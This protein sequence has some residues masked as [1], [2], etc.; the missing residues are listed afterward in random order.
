[1][2]TSHCHMFYQI[3][4]AE[5]FQSLSLKYKCENCQLFKLSNAGGEFNLA[6]EK[7]DVKLKFVDKNIVISDTGTDKEKTVNIEK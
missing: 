2:S 1:M 3:P 4:Q 7:N 5:V 6:V